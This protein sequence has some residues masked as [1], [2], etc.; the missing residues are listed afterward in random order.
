MHFFPG[1]TIRSTMDN[2]RAIEYAT[3][4]QVITDKARQTVHR[5][6][7]QNALKFMRI[8]TKKHEILIAPGKTICI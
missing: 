5:L 3:F 2:E 6:D 8:R 7:S 4:V 1:C